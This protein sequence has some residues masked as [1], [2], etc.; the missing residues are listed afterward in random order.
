M[1]IAKTL[2]GLTALSAVLFAACSSA[3]E[4]EPVIE[5]EAVAAV[6]E[7]WTGEPAGAEADY[8]DE[9]VVMAGIRLFDWQ[10]DLYTVPFYAA[11]IVTPA[12]EATK[13]EAL[14]EPEGG[15]ADSAE[16]RFWT[17]Y[18]LESRP[19]K[20]EDLGVGVLVLAM[21]DA[22]PRSRED[23]A[24]TSRW[25]LFR[26]KD[27]SNLYKG[28]VTLE[29]HDTYWNEWKAGEYHVENIRLVLGGPSTELR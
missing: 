6:S 2:F 3:P 17:P 1:K 26:V 12:S 18:L 24:A 22:T 19:A 7:E 4:P 28:T 13:G 21:G 20:P 27:S 11:T 8:L 25:A 16:T 9:G 15:V 14:V 29:Y 5:A 10:G 23:L